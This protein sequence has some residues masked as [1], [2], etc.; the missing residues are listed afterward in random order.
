[1]KLIVIIGL[2]VLAL[3]VLGQEYQAQYRLTFVGEWSPSTHPTD[4]PNNAHFSA[5]I[6]N[7][8]DENGGIWLPGLLATDGIEVMAE[9]GSTSVLTNEINDLINLGVA[10]FRLLGSS[11][12]ATQT[13]AFEFTI[14]E[15]HP[16]VSLTTMIAPSPDWF[17]GVHDLSLLQGAEWAEEVIVDLQ[18]YDSG[19][20]SG[21]TFISSNIE[22][23]P[24]QPI[25]RI[26]T[27][28]FTNGNPLGAFVFTRLSTS[29][30]PTDVLFASSFE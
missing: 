15:S 23:N 10:E 2:T 13:V 29:G 11:A 22:T 25:S 18:P 9:T 16:L 28:P 14:T 3:P 20:D 5:L 27:A 19:T 30:T 26:A 1:M 6:G 24:Q 8:H 17:I 4:Y 12:D 21:T 7:T